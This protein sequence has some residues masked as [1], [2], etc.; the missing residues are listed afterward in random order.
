[1]FEEQQNSLG[2]L[3]GCDAC[4]VLSFLK[5][6]SCEEQFESSWIADEL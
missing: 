3:D 1:M 6:E 4:W 5:G 2:A